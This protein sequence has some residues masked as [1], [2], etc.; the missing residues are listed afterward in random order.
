MRAG[1]TNTFDI[2][3]RTP[4]NTE[5]LNFE[6]YGL[7]ADGSGNSS[8]TIDW[9]EL[10]VQSRPGGLSDEAWGAIWDNVQAQT[11]KTW[12]DFV[13]M[14]G[15]NAAYLKGIGRDVYSA[16]DLLAFEVLQANGLNPETYL[17]AGEDAFTP[18][19]GLDL[20]FVRVYGQSL[21]SR[22]TDGPLG[23]GWSHNY[24]LS[25]EETDD[26]HVL[27]H[28]A[29]GSFRSFVA[30]DE[31]YEGALGEDADLT[32]NS[33]GTFQL[34]EPSGLTYRFG[35]NAKLASIRDTNGNTITASYADSQL[36]QLTHSG[37]Q[38]LTLSYNDNGNLSKAVDQ[39]NQSSVYQYD[40]TGDYLNKVTTPDNQTTTYTYDSGARSLTSITNAENNTR[41][42][43][44]D[45]IGRLKTTFL[46][47]NA[48]LVAY[49][50][51]FT[52]TVTI[53]D[54]VNSSSKILFDER[55][56]PRKLHDAEGRVYEF[57]ASLNRDLVRIVQPDSSIN[58]V[59]YDNR[60]YPTQITN[61]ASDVTALNFDSTYG[62]L[63]WV[64][65]AN[66]NTIRYHYDSTGN[67]LKIEHPD[68]S[69]EE[70]SLDLQGNLSSYT[71]RRGETTTYAYNVDGLRTQEINSGNKTT[72]YIHDIEGKLRSTVD[73]RGTAVLV[74]DDN[75]RLKTIT[76]PDNRF[77]SFQYD[78]LGRRTQLTGP[79]NY[80][81][82]YT[83]DAAGRLNQLVDRSDELIVKYSYD[84]A[85]QLSR[86]D[87]GNG[88]YTTYDYFTGGRL[89]SLTHYAPNKAINSQFDYT[90]DKLGRQDSL[91]T[92]DGKWTYGYSAV[93]ELTRATFT[94]NNPAIE[95]KDLTYVYDAVGNRVR[96]IQ[97]GI[98]T[99][100]I[101]NNLNQYKSIN[102]TTYQYDD[103]GN[104]IKKS[105]KGQVWQYDYNTENQLTRV[106]APNM[107]VTE[108]EYDI[109]DNRIATIQNG[110]RTEYLVD[111]FGIGDVVIEYDDNG[112]VARYI[113]GLGLVSQVTPENSNY[114]DFNAIGSTVGLTGAIGTY[115]N[116]YDY[117]PFGQDIAETE[118]IGNSFEFLGR[119]GITEE[120]NDLDFVRARF[121]SS[122][123]ED[124]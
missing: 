67:L 103:D 56:I 16:Q 6:L 74:Y 31:A 123:L 4:L 84:E 3:I 111:P 44:Y 107:S 71:N 42:Y 100:Y 90:Y 114:Y 50:Y 98:T 17:A 86:E 2:K 24:D 118:S 87:K 89:K 38:K 122:D 27:L 92:L 21:S 85:G 112:L 51:D 11:G 101:T 66:G 124:L 116:R 72:Q 26:G 53:T 20:R 82:K 77:L 121:Y 108:Y 88:T 80:T 69:K 54:A 97:D 95:N 105:E 78:E 99:E 52:G 46:G 109:F 59:S 48:E 102:D 29:D 58:S 115:V 36:T 83:Y 14:L 30:S 49:G 63:Q 117:L 15:E 120:S 5:P 94:S 12:A 119:W 41:T 25:V 39:D 76:Y 37:G 1:E 93:G 18:A 81:V 7:Q 64:R 91:V 43:T 13:A 104:L 62:N 47:S 10:E 96:T 60:G 35:T 34:R 23:Y 75:S 22:Y 106:I 57:T 40:A 28:W 73:E 55:G 45:N 9:D 19:P 70:F 61:P 65:D 8:Q 68:G 33:D 113:H 79:D 32:R 110:Q